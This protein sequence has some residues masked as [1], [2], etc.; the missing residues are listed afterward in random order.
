MKTAFYDILLKKRV[1]N[2]YFYV[3]SLKHCQKK[4]QGL[5]TKPPNEQKF[6]D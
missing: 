4:A 3:F 5:M 6:D 2:G 1:L